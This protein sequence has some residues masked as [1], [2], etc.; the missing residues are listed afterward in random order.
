MILL[1]SGCHPHGLIQPLAVRD[2]YRILANYK[3]SE[4]LNY[5]YEKYETGT[6][7]T[8]LFIQ[9]VHGVE[10]L[11]LVRIFRSSSLKSQVVNFG[12][13]PYYMRKIYPVHIR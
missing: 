7:I 8:F 9:M 3:L 10:M 2:I 6:V 11:W 4:Y 5:F 12:T 1:Q 13:D